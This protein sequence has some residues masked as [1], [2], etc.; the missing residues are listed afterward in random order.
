MMMVRL[1]VST[2][3]RMPAEAIQAMTGNHGKVTMASSQDI[4][5]SSKD[6]KITRNVYVMLQFLA[7]NQLY[8]CLVDCCV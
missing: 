3:M 2:V 7:S 6:K 4:T 8:S 5:A 1:K